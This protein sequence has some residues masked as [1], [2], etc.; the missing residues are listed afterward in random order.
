MN[1]GELLLYVI[2]RPQGTRL[3]TFHRKRV[4]T[5][6]RWW[7][8]YERYLWAKSR[9]QVDWYFWL[10]YIL[11]FHEWKFRT[12]TDWHRIST[13]D[14][15]ISLLCSVHVGRYRYRYCTYI[16]YW[17]FTY[18]H[19]SKRFLFHT[20]CMSHPNYLATPR[21][22]HI[23]SIEKW[24]YLLDDR[25][26]FCIY[27]AMNVSFSVKSVSISFHSKPTQSCPYIMSLSYPSPIPPPPTQNNLS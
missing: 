27:V 24:S 15:K 2:P 11:T 4:S 10:Y 19:L 22:T 14:R 18:A 12:S 1:C 25:H 6:V 8:V 17:H 13:K 26:V 16:R 7:G 21:L 23:P 9:D 3:P 20:W 5:S